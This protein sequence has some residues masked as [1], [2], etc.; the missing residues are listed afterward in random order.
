MKLNFLT[1]DSYIKLLKPIIKSPSKEFAQYVKEESKTS[2][3]CEYTTQFIDSQVLE[4]LCKV[5][6]EKFPDTDFA[7]CSP[8]KQKKYLKDDFKNKFHYTLR[9][10]VCPQRNLYIRDFGVTVNEFCRALG[11]TSTKVKEQFCYY[12]PKILNIAIN[13][14]ITREKKRLYLLQQ[15]SNVPQICTPEQYLAFVEFCIDFDEMGFLKIKNIKEEKN[16]N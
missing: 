10:Y 3:T 14:L 4:S 11:M 8:E 6:S 9:K 7:Q 13:N 12:E 5:V 2:K 1:R 16:D 15:F